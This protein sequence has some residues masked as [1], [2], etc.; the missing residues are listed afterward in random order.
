M[1]LSQFIHYGYLTQRHDAIIRKCNNE[2]ILRMSDYMPPVP[3]YKVVKIPF[4]R[5]VS[6]AFSKNVYKEIIN[7]TKI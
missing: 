7:L 2:E 6:E 1:T 3:E 4:T 5:A